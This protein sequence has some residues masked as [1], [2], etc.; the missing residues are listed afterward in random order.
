MEKDTSASTTL[1]SEEEPA[2]LGY[3]NSV[4]TACS[5]IEGTSIDP[6]VE[7]TYVTE[8]QLDATSEGEVDQTSS[9]SSNA[10]QSSVSQRTQHSIEEFQDPSVS[11][12]L[13]NDIA[14]PATDC[15]NSN[16][17]SSIIDQAGAKEL[18]NA[19]KQY[20]HVV[21]AFIPDW[22]SKI[23]KRFGFVRFIKV[24][25]AESH[26]LHAN[27]A[28]FQRPTGQNSSRNFGHNGEK[29]KDDKGNNRNF[30]S[31]AHVL[32]GVSH[33]NGN[34]TNTP[35]LVIGDDCFNELGIRYLGGLWVMLVFRS[36]DGKEKF[37]VN[38][39]TNFWFSRLIE[40]SSDFV[41][42]GRVAWVKEDYYHNKCM[43]IFTA[44]MVNIF[45]P[46]K[47]IYQG[48]TFWVRA[49]EV[50]G[51]CP[52]F[53]EQLDKDSEPKDDIFRG[54]DKPDTH[55]SEEEFEDE[56]VVPNTVFD[57]GSVKPSVVENSSGNQGNKSED[58]F[59]LYSLLNKNK[60]EK[61]K[62]SIC[63]ES[64]K[65]PPSFTPS[66]E[67]KVGCNMDKPELNCDNLNG[68]ASNQEV[69]G[70]E[71]LIVETWSDNV[72]CGS[73]DMLNLMYKLKN[74][75][76]KIRGW[77][78]ERNASEEV[79]YKRLEIVNSINEL[80]K[81]QAMETTQKAKIKWAI[82]GDEN[83]KYYHGILSKKR[84]NLAIRGVFEARKWI[85]NPDLVK[86]EFL[87]H[88]KNRFG[89]PNKTRHVVVK[90]FPRQLN[91]MQ[92]MDME[93]DDVV[94][95]VKCFFH[96]GSIPKGCNSSFIAL[97][98]KIPDVKMVK[99][100]RPISLIGS[101]YKIIAKILANRLVMVLGDVINEI[102]S[103]FVADK[104]ILDG[105]FILNEVL[106]WCKFEEKIV[107]HFKIDFEK[108]Y[109]SVRWDYLEDV[110]KKFG[111]E[112]NDNVVDVGMFKGI[113][114]NSSMVLSHMV[115]ADDAVFV[116]QWSNSNID[117]IIYALKCFEMASG[118]CMNMSKSKIMGIV[119]NGDKKMKTLSI[120]GR[121]TLIKAMLGAISIYH[122]S[123]FKAVQL[124]KMEDQLVQLI[125]KRDRWAW[126]QN[127]SGEFSVA[128]IRRLLD[129]IRLSEVSFQ[130]R[131]IDINSILCPICEMEVES[132]S[133]VFFSCYVAKDNFK[134]VCRWW[135]MDFAEVSSYDERLLWISSLRIHDKHKKVLEGVC[136][137]L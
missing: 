3:N 134:K 110:L 67:K 115:F 102:Q 55:N 127:G 19:C 99:D 34:T 98:P 71:K 5:V 135:N 38:V 125:N 46:F 81:Q 13:G 24:F 80:E 116:G 58:P 8:A 63:S 66:V 86:K 73:N 94:A 126:S 40:T 96:Y 133:H 6:C 137:G 49:K 100:F 18:W 33:P 93:A 111:F 23:G 56:N 17:S 74:L 45:E 25:D 129:D 64:L 44:D 32:K 79:I 128:S 21:D 4:L 88:F 42:D 15:N 136:Y 7:T 106:Q 92:C 27:I 84:N 117:T 41:V 76:K 9:S 60:G 122:M 131:V 90:E 26:R 36:V 69:N 132:V 30:N 70:F 120:G 109:D 48:K 61:N 89:R 54:V 82:K 37:K 104:Q 52:E 101:L 118:L 105:P 113:V 50:P 28:R 62:D 14:V 20:G 95:V 103:A 107:V 112:E 121:L 91:S 87:N 39:G 119:V 130:T 75:K 83:S 68:G 31:F 43:C 124:A 2:E 77:N 35:S 72:A 108:A 114:L 29:R 47:I 85:K 65:F 123:I 53:E 1:T 12:T 78:N 16:H 10:S 22:R 97:I 11:T 57:D 51:W 59:D